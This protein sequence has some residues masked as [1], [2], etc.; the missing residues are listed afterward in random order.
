MPIATGERDTAYTASDIL[1]PGQWP[2][3]VS[4]SAAGLDVSCT[5]IA[6]EFQSL[7]T[8][9]AEAVIRR[10]LDLLR[11]ATATDVAFLVM[12]D[13]A[14]TVCQQV[15]VAKGL[16]TQ[17]SPEALRGERLE[18]YPA[19]RERLTHIDAVLYT[20][21]H[22]D[23]ILGLDD[24]RPLSF[25]SQRA[26]GP[27]PLYATRET[28]AVLERIAAGNHVTANALGQQFELTSDQRA[29]VRTFVARLKAKDQT[30][31]QSK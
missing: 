21:S 22:A 1:A 7:E 24:L 4:R 31:N 11:E 3:A 13:A 25:G 29:A 30:Q 28:A 17:C 26:G 9:S 12:Y 19:L 27:M 20:H 10:N 5:K 8:A 14:L 23:H 16:F 15:E 2:P 18:R 6:I